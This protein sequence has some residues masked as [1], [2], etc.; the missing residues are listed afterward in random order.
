MSSLFTLII[1]GAVINLIVRAVSRRGGLTASDDAGTRIRRFFQYVALFA[2]LV[3]VAIGL[4]G[5]IAAAL[6]QGDLLVRDSTEAARSLAFLVVGIPLYA[7]LFRWVWLALQRDQAERSSFGWAFYLTVATLTSLATAALAASRTLQWAFAANDWSPQAAAGAVVWGSALVAHIWLARRLGDDQ[8]LRFMRVAAAVGGLAA[9]ATS[10]GLALGTT[11]DWVYNRVNGTILVDNLGKELRIA[12]SVA[13]VAAPIWWWYWLRNVAVVSR[14]RLWAAYALLAGV[15]SGVLLVLGALGAILYTGLEWWLGEASASTAAAQFEVLPGALAAVLIGTGLWT[16]HRSVLP[17]RQTRFEIDRVYEYL[18][19][20]VGLL[21]ATGGL[22]TLVVAFIE[23]I[24][25]GAIAE[26]GTSATNTLLVAVTFLIMGA[27]LW[28]I[29]WSRVQRTAARD[30]SETRSVTR[31]SYLSVFFGLAGAASVISLLVAFVMSFEAISQS[32]FGWD[33]VRDMRVAL[34]LVMTIGTL[35]AYH[36][37]VWK[38]D[39]RHMPKDHVTVRDVTLV[40][41]NGAHA[42]DQVAERV[43]AKVHRWNR[44]D[45]TAGSVDIEELVAAL[46]NQQTHHVL[47]VVDEE[48]DFELVPV[49]SA[50]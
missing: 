33:T 10:F 46:Q 19:A 45:M 14:A 3:I 6:P 16:Y 27:P 37:T 26:V 41:T 7:A 39:R 8:R 28:W 18:L 24:A 1:L 11:F 21:A 48:G 23:T 47:V 42:A 29:F 17:A 38:T 20:S 2:S 5:L 13:L 32:E 36:W 43:G 12:A 30:D 15:L 40:S 35:A 25:P 50:R 34:A 44:L 22:T 31:R 9:L 4:S 49:G